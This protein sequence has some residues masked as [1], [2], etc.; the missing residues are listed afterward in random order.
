MGGSAAPR[1][2]EQGADTIV[3]LATLPDGGPSGQFF[4]DRKPI[5]W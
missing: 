1:S 4:K 2:V 3:W 5:P